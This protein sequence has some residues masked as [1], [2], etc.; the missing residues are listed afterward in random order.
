MMDGKAL[1][2]LAEN[3]KPD[4]IIGCGTIMPSTAAARLSDL[5]PAWIDLFGDAIA[6]LQSKAEMYPDGPN[7]EELHHV[8]RMV[9]RCLRAGD[10]FS[11]LSTA[12]MHATIGALGLLGRISGKT[13]GAPMVHSI[14]CAIMPRES[15]GESAP[16]VF[17]GVKCPQDAFLV[18]WSGSY[19]TW[20]DPDLLFDG[21]CG[22]MAQSS[23][24]H[25]VSTGGGSPG[26][27]EDIYA[28]FKT[29]AESCALSDR[30]H[31]LGWIPRDEAERIQ[32]ECDVGLN[33]DRWCYE[34]VLGSRNRIINFLDIGVPVVTTILSELSRDLEAAGGVIGIPLG[35]PARFAETFAALSESPEKLRESASKG[36]AFVRENYSI[37][38]TTLPLLEWAASP[39]RATDF[40]P[41]GGY[42]N[43]VCAL[44]DFDAVEEQLI[45]IQSGAEGGRIR[46][47]LGRLGR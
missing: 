45:R 25:F 4:A 20:I 24:L 33:I 6:E 32:R 9:Q 15:S 17:R 12:Q 31:F 38:K 41:D 29:R 27:N 46:R 23:R 16:P 5:A 30:F 14:P 3:V 47:M 10:R 1:R 40:D 44:T 37:E 28:K 42:A 22:A 26:Y 43:G 18:V 35:N 13:A 7:D 34:G 21:L 19:N 11:T 2:A 39:V 36:W 8:W